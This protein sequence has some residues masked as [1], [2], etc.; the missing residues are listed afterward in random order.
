MNKIA[1]LILIG[2]TLIML[3]V[4]GS[5][6]YQ[7]KEAEKIEAVAKQ[8]TAVF[9]REHSQTLGREDA[10]VVVSE[11]LDP[12][13]ETCRAFHPFL[14][15]MLAHYEGK[16]KLVIR[17]APLHHGS[18][19]MVSILEASKEQGKYW[20]T[21]DVMYDS[22]PYWASHSD[23]KPEM[24]WQFLPHIGLDIDKLK[25]DM[26]SPMIANIIAQDIADAK[27]LN[28]RKTPQFFVN[29][30]PLMVFGDR[31]LVEL[32]ESEVVKQYPN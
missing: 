6:F 7:G 29:G 4:L 12:G 17:Y 22:Q 24:I 8:D 26:R 21:L 14:K 27:A 10:K 13:C 20:E 15:E 28:V 5:F 23:P 3:F 2:V 25:E 1:I 19:T 32:V 16:V 9:A 18:D 31:E 11:F 30:R